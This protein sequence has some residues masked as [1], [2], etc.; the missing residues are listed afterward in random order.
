M[1]GH[2][3]SSKSV[4]LPEFYSWSPNRVTVETFQLT[5][6]CNFDF[7]EFP[8]D[9]HD[10]P[11]EYG[12]GFYSLKQMRLSKTQAVFGNISTK[13]GGD[14]I[15]VDNLPFPFEFRL[16]VLPTFE[17]RNIYKISF[18]YTSI[19]LKMRRKSP[20]QLI[21]GYFYPTAAFALLSMVSFLIKPDLVSCLCRFY[22]QSIL[23]SINFISITYKFILKYS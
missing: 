7:S 11:I 18:S 12:S 19:V 20:G 14:P 5:F 10:C 16:V 4:V 21:C 3:D 8:F 1:Y 23:F 13:F 17:L 22:F 9:S 6:S 15:I 2:T